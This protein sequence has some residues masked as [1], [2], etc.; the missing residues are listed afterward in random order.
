M[1]P[2]MT[3]CVRVWRWGGLLHAVASFLRGIL[4][5]ATATAP[6][7]RLEISTFWCRV[8]GRR[9]LDALCSFQ[10]AAHTLS[11]QLYSWVWSLVEAAQLVEFRD[12]WKEGPSP[13]QSV[14]VDP[15]RPVRSLHKAPASF[16]A[17]VLARQLSQKQLYSKQRK[18]KRNKQ[19]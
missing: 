11:D 13:S 1:G 9:L 18:H 17:P 7:A 15:C 3:L 2:I 19:L 4:Q 12:I 16:P 14:E 10:P 6:A 5:R 8:E